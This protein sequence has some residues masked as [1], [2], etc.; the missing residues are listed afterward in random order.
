MRKADIVTK[1]AELTGI[2]KAD[3]LL[4]LEAFFSEVKN[5]VKKGENVYVRG[6][7][8]F[9]AKKRAQKVGRIIKRNETIIIPAHY[10][11][12]FK[13]AKTFVDSVK[14]G[15]VGAAPKKTP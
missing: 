11:P 4:S 15:R 9:I 2:P 1:V 13:P 12:A 5:S 6:F 14:K 10:I 8:S 3:V 7:G